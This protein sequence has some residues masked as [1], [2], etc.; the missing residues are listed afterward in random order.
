MFAGLDE[1]Y[2]PEAGPRL[3]A[4]LDVAEV[5]CLPDEVVRRL[6]AFVE[7]EKRACRPSEASVPGNPHPKAP[8]GRAGH[9]R[10]PQ[11]AP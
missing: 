10:N 3:T 1:A 5:L 7:K 6:V 2:P 8:G 11:L 4:L 9:W